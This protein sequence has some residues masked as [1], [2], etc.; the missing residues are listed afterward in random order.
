GDGRRSV[1]VSEIAVRCGAGETIPQAT[2]RQIDAA[3]TVP[4]RH[5]GSREWNR[6]SFRWNDA[7]F[8]SAKLG[9]P[10]GRQLW[11]RAAAGM[12]SA[13]AAS[14][15]CVCSLLPL[16]AEDAEPRLVDELTSFVA[17]LP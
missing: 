12:T 5:N 2:K 16:A 3:P 14:A 15:A 8:R 1:L 13:R 11:G 10:L 4:A 9:H 17:V 7:R 6:A